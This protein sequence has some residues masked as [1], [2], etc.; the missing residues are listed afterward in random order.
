MRRTI[1]IRLAAI[2]ALSVFTAGTYIT[3]GELDISWLR[4]L[5]AAVFITTVLLALWDTWI[6]RF[7]WIQLIPGVPRNVRGT[8]KGTVTPFWEDPSTG[9]RRDPKPAYLVIR[10]TATLVSACLLTDESK[11]ASSLAAVSGSDGAVTLD[12][13]Y[14]NRP[15]ASVEDRSRMHHGSTVLEIAGKPAKRMEGRYWTDRDTR[16]ELVFIR[17][18]GKLADDYEDAVHLFGDENAPSGV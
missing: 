2:V 12:Y 7:P 3:S 11:S 18:S 14:L 15:K 8:W 10:Q 5:S 1:V 4:F 9:K 17:R 6:W 13:L 16:G